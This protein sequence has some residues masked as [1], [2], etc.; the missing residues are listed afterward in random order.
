M[1]LLYMYIKKFDDSIENQEIIFTNNFDVTLTDGILKV[2]KKE[3]KLSHLY[4]PNIKNITV[5]NGKNGTGKSTILDILG[6]NRSDRIDASYMNDSD[7]IKDEYFILYYLYT[8]DDGRDIYG[9]EFIGESIFTEVIKN[10]EIGSSKDYNNSKICIGIQFYYDGETFKDTNKHFF[11]KYKSQY[12]K[13]SE[14][15]NIILISN[16]INRRERIKYDYMAIK[17]KDDDY[18]G[19]RIYL[20]KDEASMYFMIDKLKKNKSVKFIN[21]SATVEINDSIENRFYGD[22]SS[23]E[24]EEFSKIEKNLNSQLPVYYK[25]RGF[26]L[27]QHKKKLNFQKELTSK[28]KKEKYILDLCSR[29]IINLFLIGIYGI[30]QSNNDINKEYYKYDKHNKKSVILNLNDD[31]HNDFVNKLKTTSNSYDILGKPTDLQIEK[32][33]LYKI[34]KYY[35]PKDDKKKFI[36]KLNKLINISRYLNSRLQ[37]QYEDEENAYEDAFENLIKNILKLKSE[38]FIDKHIVIPL[39]KNTQGNNVEYDNNV[40][41]LLNLF[42]EYRIHEEEKHNQII[43]MFNINY[44]KLSEGENKLIEIFSKLYY[45]GEKSRE[46]GLIILLLDEP[47]QAL[48]PEW[49]RIFMNLLVDILEKSKYNVQVVLTTHSPYLLSD[50]FPQNVYRLKRSNENY[51]DKL[52][53]DRLSNVEGYSCFGANIYDLLSN[54]FFMDNSIGEFATKKIKETIE[55]IDKLNK[56]TSSK[57]KEEI[58]VVINN[59]GEHILRQE[60]EKKYLVKINE[61]EKLSNEGKTYEDILKIISNPEEREKVKCLLQENRRDKL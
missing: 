5:M 9:I 6:M 51:D 30:I 43:H 19:K 50:M 15:L 24:K 17:E 46:N 39:I 35:N 59:I 21:K 37:A 8:E 7:E 13:L 14:N 34:I 61:I 53:I 48:H 20:G 29:Y 58:L 40:Y 52:K 3:N 11:S 31:I 38:Y 41:D 45:A 55:K 4:Q 57:E 60:I 32:E 26:V 44:N 1:E 16:D 27:S 2:R 36:D 54:S 12:E 10:C 47:D 42:K 25:K 56:Y 28:E 23:K 18:L 33:N 22:D 49:N